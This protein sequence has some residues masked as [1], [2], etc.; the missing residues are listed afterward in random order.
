M[1]EP[2]PFRVNGERAGLMVFVFSALL[3]FW[4]FVA[5]AD[6]L[7]GAVSINGKNVSS[8]ADPLGF[9]LSV[10]AIAVAELYALIMLIRYVAAWRFTKDQDK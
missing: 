3:L 10:I 5:V 7:D 1:R 4:S 8:T 6:V 9:W 2:N